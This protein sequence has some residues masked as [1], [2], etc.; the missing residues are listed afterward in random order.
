MPIPDSDKASA[1]GPASSAE[2]PAPIER[3]VVAQAPV[4]DTALAEIRRGAKRSHWM[5][6][7]F[8]QLHM[9]GRS[10]QAKYFGIRSLDEARAYLA[11][12]VLGPRYLEC[13]AA[14]QDLSTSDPERV[15]GATDAMKLRSSLTLFEVA[16]AG[17]S[18][19]AALDRWFRG[20]RDQTTL[21]W[22][23]R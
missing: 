12:P 20:A 17:P 16:G 1:D 13:V 11:H 14:L 18:V 19:R 5:W 22:L 9:L 21:S 7:V 6:Y 23:A 3:F 10:E 15:F 8:P 2:D 4:Y